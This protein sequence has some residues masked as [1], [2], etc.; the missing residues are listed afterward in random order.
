[1]ALY[2]IKDGRVYNILILIIRIRFNESTA[3]IIH[4]CYRVYTYRYTI[5]RY[6]LC[7]YTTTPPGLSI[8]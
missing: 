5:Y 1:M 6:I 8:C 7:Y 3:V 4:L 2:T